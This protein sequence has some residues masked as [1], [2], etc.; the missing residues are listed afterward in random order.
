[1]TSK[2]DEAS[3]TLHWMDGSRAQSILWLLEE[4]HIPYKLDIHHRQKTLAAP[5]SLARLHPLGKAPLLTVHPPKDAQSQ[6]IVLA[7]SGFIIQYLC[8]HWGGS[9]KD[10]APSLLPQKWRQGQEGK[11]GGETKEWMR[12][13]YLLNYVEGSLMP[14]VWLYTIMQIL[15]GPSLPFFIRPITGMVGGQLTSNL[16]FPNVVKHFGMLEGFLN[17]DVGGKYMCG[18]QLTAADIL[19]S[20]PLLSL[21]EVGALATLGAWEKGTPE[22][23]YPKLFEYVKRMAD[24]PGYARAADKIRELEGEFRVAPKLS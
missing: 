10:E 16:I 19:L 6:D 12:C 24:E 21:H 9:G 4:L 22:E 14:Y 2:S 7:E 17:D 11:V 3:V 1:M 13:Q 8:D 18:S 5:S 15:K 23:T 20:Y